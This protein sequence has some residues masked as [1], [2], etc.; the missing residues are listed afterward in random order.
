MS[1]PPFS[2]IDFKNEMAW[3]LN[4]GLPTYGFAHAK[5]KTSDFS[6]KILELVGMAPISVSFFMNF[7]AD[8]LN[9]QDWSKIHLARKS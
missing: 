4:K 3:V 6:S 1:N 8:F 2:D 5:V 9:Y 7:K